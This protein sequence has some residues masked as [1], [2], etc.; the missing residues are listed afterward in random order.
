MNSLRYSDKNKLIE[1]LK[2]IDPLNE[3]AKLNLTGNAKELW[4]AGIRDIRSQIDD[5]N[6]LLEIRTDKSICLSAVFLHRFSDIFC[7]Y[8]IN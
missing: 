5:L 7:C 3:Q 6:E 1:Q 8:M 2:V 4:I